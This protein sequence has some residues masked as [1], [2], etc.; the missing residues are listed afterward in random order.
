M[1]PVFLSLTGEHIPPEQTGSF[2]WAQPEGL[3]CKDRAW[4]NYN[5]SPTSNRDR[6]TTDGEKEGEY[7]RCGWYRSRQ[8]RKGQ[9]RRQK[10][11]VEADIQYVRIFSSL[12]VRVTEPETLLVVSNATW[13]PTY[14][15]HAR[16]SSSTG[17]PSSQVTL[18]YQ[19]SIT[20]ST[21]EDWT[22]SALILSSGSSFHRFGQALRMPTIKHIKIGPDMSG[23]NAGTCSFFDE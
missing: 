1:K 23:P 12:P 2:F 17:Q 10:G 14:E 6:R 8:W 19:A 4:W 3:I 22:D 16:T 18:H 11:R 5:S 7:Q 13:E 15:L 21:G 20:Q 9:G